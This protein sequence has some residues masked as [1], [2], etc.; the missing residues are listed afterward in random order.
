MHPSF[1]A[2]VCVYFGPVKSDDLTEM[3]CVCYLTAVV[4]SSYKGVRGFRESTYLFQH[5]PLTLGL[6]IGTVSQRFL[7]NL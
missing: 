3:C 7:R 2:T 5:Q 6:P 1:R 4:Q